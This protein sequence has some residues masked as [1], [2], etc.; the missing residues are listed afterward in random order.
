MGG[1]RGRNRKSR[2]KGK[3]VR[4]EESAV[5]GLEKQTEGDGREGMI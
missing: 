2:R 5:K 1:S 4:I 3:S